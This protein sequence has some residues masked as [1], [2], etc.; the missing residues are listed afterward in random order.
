MLITQALQRLYFPK[1]KLYKSWKPGAALLLNVLTPTRA[2]KIKKR[3]SY[4]NIF[5]PFT[6]DEVLCCV[7]EKRL[8]KNQYI[9]LWLD[10]KKRNSNKFPSY[11]SVIGPKKRYYPD[12]YVILE[13]N[14]EIPL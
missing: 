6:L 14:C 12:S 13:S 4:K 5:I 2:S 11:D 1:T 10:A 3:L 8:L 7:I 9:G